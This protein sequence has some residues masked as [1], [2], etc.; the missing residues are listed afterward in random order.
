MKK[1]KNDGDLEQ[2]PAF[3]DPK[4]DVLNAIVETPKGSRSKYK[5]DP[6]HSLFKLKTL[7]PVGAVF[8]FDFGFIPSTTAEDGD[9]ID[10]LILMD[11]P[12]AVGTL[13][14]VRL[15]GVLEAEQTEKP[16]SG[17]QTNRN[18]RLIAVSSVSYNYSDIRSLNDLNDHLIEEIEH[19]FVSY[20]ESRG[21]KLK[22]LG[23]YGP[24]RALDLVKEAEK[25]KRKQNSGSQQKKAA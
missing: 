2:L 4:N 23:R 14:E 1:N 21:T 22:L 5:F 13:I 19:F 7:L 9:P 15:V 16:E 10:V 11:E 3:A 24:K 6:E 12:V 20:N 8:P 18:D 17:R 25:R